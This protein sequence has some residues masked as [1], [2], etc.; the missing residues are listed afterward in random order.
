MAALP[1]HTSDDPVN[2]KIQERV[3]NDLQKQ[4]KRFFAF[5][6]IMGGTKEDWDAYTY[7]TRKDDGDF[8][9]VCSKM[10]KGDKSYKHVYKNTS[11]GRTIEFGACCVGA[12][13]AQEKCG[14]CG[15]VHAGLNDPEECRDSI[16]KQ[17]DALHTRWLR[18][19]RETGETFPL[20][21]FVE[22]D[23]Q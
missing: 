20:E 12:R 11:T 18:I 6:R 2:R 5:L 13:R 3:D 21:Y 1:E 17:E 10:V 22:R 8:Q 16:L 4:K 14:K 19:N 15:R 7:E 23:S 9:C